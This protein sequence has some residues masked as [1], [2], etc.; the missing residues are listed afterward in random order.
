[1]ELFIYILSFISGGVVFTVAYILKLTR[2][3]H[4]RQDD[5]EHEHTINMDLFKVGIKDFQH[6]QDRQIDELTLI[7][8][9]MES[10][11]YRD[12]VSTNQNINETKKSLDILAKHVNQKFI[13]NKEQ[14]G[15][16]MNEI[17]NRMVAIDKNIQQ[18]LKNDY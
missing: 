1:M 10:D 14:F 4:Q 6:R 5:F 3:T 15:G 16:A 9:E 7:R 17:Q 12:L 13:E 8:S 18:N 11:T 2:E